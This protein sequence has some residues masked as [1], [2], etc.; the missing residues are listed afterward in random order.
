MLDIRAEDGLPSYQRQVQQE[1]GWNESLEAFQQPEET[2]TYSTFWASLH[3]FRPST[4]IQ[5][6]IKMVLWNYVMRRMSCFI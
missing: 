1:K 2:N 6:V 3:M 4:Q 5:I